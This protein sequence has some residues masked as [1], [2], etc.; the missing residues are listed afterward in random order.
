MATKAL[1]GL[2]KSGVEPK[3][4]MSQN[5]V[6]YMGGE[7]GPFRCDHCE[8]FKAPSSCAIVEGQ[9]DPEGCCNVYEPAPASMTSLQPTISIPSEPAKAPSPLK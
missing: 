6:V 7:L 9:I 5:A 2:K 1:E 3:H 8:Y 4:L